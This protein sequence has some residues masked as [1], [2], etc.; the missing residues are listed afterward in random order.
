MA[1]H[2]NPIREFPM[3]LSIASNA[4][5]DML[6]VALHQFI[7][8]NSRADTVLMTEEAVRRLRELDSEAKHM[9]RQISATETLML[10]QPHTHDA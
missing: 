1:H 2:I 8:S 7:E 4:R 3:F 10:N 9:L 5:R 6:K